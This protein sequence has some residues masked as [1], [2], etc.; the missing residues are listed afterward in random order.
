MKEQ[1]FTLI[2]LLIVIAIAMI[3]IG[4]AITGSKSLQSQQILKSTVSNFVS[5]LNFIKSEAVSGVHTFNGNSDL[6]SG[7]S[8]NWVYGF[9]IIPANGVDTVCNSNCSGYNIVMAVKDIVS[10]NQCL[11]QNSNNSPI[12]NN[13]LP[14]QN[15]SLYNN[16]TTNTFS[17]SVSPMSACIGNSSGLNNNSITPSGYTYFHTFTPGVTVSATN[18]PVFEEISGYIYVYSVTS[19]YN[20]VSS[21]S[22]ST[23]AI[24]TFSYQ[25]YQ[26]KVTV[27]DIYN[28]ST[29]DSVSIGGIKYE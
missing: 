17:G 4:F 15:D 5:K 9:Y 29:S 1:G 25:G 11:D 19:P 18:F 12:F 8:K 22:S 26:E 21:P 14:P 20:I 10:G 3:L 24:F 28:S 6:S 7:I 2:E 27:N 13:I 23:S 16:V